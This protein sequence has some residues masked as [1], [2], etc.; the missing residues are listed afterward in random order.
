M[1]KTEQLSTSTQK[2]KIEL[3][4]KKLVGVKPTEKKDSAKLPKPT[5]WRIL[6]LPFKQKEKTKGGILL[7]DETVERSQ[8]ASTCGLVLRMGPHCYD[9]ERFPEG[10]WAKKG[11]WTDNGSVNPIAKAAWHFVSRHNPRVAYGQGDPVPNP[12]NVSFFDVLKAIAKSSI[13]RTMSEFFEG[14]NSVLENKLKG[15]V[16]YPDY[17]WVRLNNPRQCKKGGGSR[18]K[19]LIVSDEWGSMT[20]N[21]TSSSF[22][23]TYEY[24]TEE[25]YSSGVASYEPLLGGDE[26]P[27]REPIYTKVQNLL[28]PDDEHYIERPLGESFFPGPGIGYSRVVIRPL[29][30]DGVSVHEKGYSV[31]EFYT[32]KDFPTRTSQTDLSVLPAKTGDLSNILKLSTIKDHITAS[33]GYLIE[34]NDMHGKPKAKAEFSNKDVKISST[35]YFYSTKEVTVDIDDQTSVQI[36]VL[37]NDVT[38]VNKDGTVSNGTMG[39]DI[40][41]STDFRESETKTR[42]VATNGNLNTFLALILPLAVVTVIPN[43]SKEETRFRSAV[44]TKVVRRSGILR[45]IVQNNMGAEVTTENLAYDAETGALL[46][47]SYNNEFHEKLYSFTYPAHWAYPGMEQAYKNAGM[48]FTISTDASGVITTGWQNVARGDQ[49]YVYDPADSRNRMRA[50]VW[51]APIQSEQRESQGYG[52]R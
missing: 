30:L 1:T 45:K 15:A 38:L 50:W 39:L 32:A 31:T 4:D 43:L 47:N 36:E 26:N 2:P 13:I 24:I 34:V 46:L 27:F 3:P 16:F 42:N 12:G 18:V 19:R 8:V 51:S 23:Q 14:R 7:A 44:A 6:V 37:D 29:N 48:E 20:N 9:K 21:G 11:D 25:G 28:A 35:E 40:D 5:G 17:S 52:T 10:P 22:G 49:L 41:I 33:Q